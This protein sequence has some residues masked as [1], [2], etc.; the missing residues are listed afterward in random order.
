MVKQSHQTCACGHAHCS[1]N[2]LSSPVLVISSAS[3]AASRALTADNNRLCQ[4]PVA[5]EAIS[6]LSHQFSFSCLHH[7]GVPS[8]PSIIHGDST[9]RFF[10]SKHFRDSNTLSCDLE[11]EPSFALEPTPFR[12]MCFYWLDEH[13]FQICVVHPISCIRALKGHALIHTLQTLN[14]TPH[15]RMNFL[16]A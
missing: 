7:G 1:Q 12:P 8:L 16:C 4:T 2:L 15:F 3:L 14:G 13:S 10:F 11:S 6:S 9:L 5:N